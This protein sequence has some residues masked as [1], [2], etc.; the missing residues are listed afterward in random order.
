MT[1]SVAY[2]NFELLSTHG[3]VCLV[4]LGGGGGGDVVNDTVTSYVLVSFTGGT[5]SYYT[6]WFLDFCWFCIR[7][8]RGYPN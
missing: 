2:L 7:S 6:H 4:I 8:E 3:T 5:K 1:A